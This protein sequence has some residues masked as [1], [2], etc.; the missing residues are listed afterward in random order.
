MLPLHVV[1]INLKLGGDWVPP[2]LENCEIPIGLEVVLET[3]VMMLR[4]PLIRIVTSVDRGLILA[5]CI[6]SWEARVTAIHSS[7][8]VLI[9]RLEWTL[10]FLNNATSPCFP[11]FMHSLT[12]DHA[13]SFRSSS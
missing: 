9:V 3:V 11:C 8:R 7:K 1:L 12:F 13:R 4:C 5:P 10:N 2:V 6:V